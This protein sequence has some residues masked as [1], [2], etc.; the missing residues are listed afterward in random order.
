MPSVFGD[1][2]D[3]IHGSD[4]ETSS[5]GFLDDGG[6]DDEALGIVHIDSWCTDEFIEFS[7]SLTADGIVG[8]ETYESL[9]ECVCERISGVVGDKLT[10]N[11]S[12]R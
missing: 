9:V 3:C 5:D 2:V 8:Q 6:E 7:L 1:L 12:R 11:L 10:S 4:D